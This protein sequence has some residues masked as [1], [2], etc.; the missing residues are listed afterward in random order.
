LLG[1]SNEWTTKSIAGRDLLLAVSTAIW[2]ILLSKEQFAVA[3]ANVLLF[4]DGI[5]CRWVAM[6]FSK[7]RIGL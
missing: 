3:A 4:D 6:I 5:S 2:S 1:S 7:L